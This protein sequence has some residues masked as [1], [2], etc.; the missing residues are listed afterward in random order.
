MADMTGFD[1]LGGTCVVTLRGELDAYTT[2]AL[3]LDL[4]RLVAEPTLSMLVIDLSNVTFLDSSALGAI[5]GALRVLRERGGE[6][7]IVKPQSAAAR[8][9]H[10]TGLD[11][12]LG[13]YPTREQA[14]SGETG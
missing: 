8:I 13:L 11:A 5:V 12:V 7:R 9:F 4:H 14:L 6:L 2:P 3:R 10:Q 1:N